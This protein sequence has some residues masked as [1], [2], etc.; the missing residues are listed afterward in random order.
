MD[1][2]K[3]KFYNGLLR[4]IL[5]SIITW[6]MALITI[7]IFGLEDN[8]DVAS[9]IIVSFAIIAAVCEYNRPEKD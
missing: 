5:V 4:A 7:H 3:V 2:K 9:R 6:L 1:Y 8:A